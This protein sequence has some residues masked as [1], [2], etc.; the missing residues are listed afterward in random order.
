MVLETLRRLTSGPKPVIAVF[1]L[2]LTSLYLLSAAT[3]DS[4]D[5]GRMYSLLL[6]INIAALLLLAALI[7]RQLLHLVRQYRQRAP[8]ARLTGRL[9]VMFVILAV[10]P[11][12]VV[13][14]FSL[15][16]LHRGIES[17][18]DVKV[19]QALED[20]L[21]L[22]QTSLDGR[23]HELL[24]STR[25][26][27]IELEGV[28]KG[29][30][31]LRLSKLRQRVAASEITLLTHEG[32]VIA[33]AA[34]SSDIV[35][36]IP[37]SAVLFQLRQGIDYVGL[38]PTEGE[39]LQARI[40]VPVMNHLG[41]TDFRIL[42]A[43]YPIGE[44]VAGLA[45]SVQ[46]AYGQYKE[47]AYLR[48]PLK[49]SF[50]LTLSLVLLLSLL[51]AVW[52]AFFSARRL[53]APIR[54]LA[55]GTR[56]VAE[57]DYDKRLP[58]P[59]R[60]ELGF[61]V[62][63]FN[64][65]TRKIA[66]SR[67]E[68]SRSQGEV[69]AQR[70]YLEVVLG[71]LSSGVLT[72]NRYRRIRA[73]NDA[74]AHI[75]RLSPESLV[76]L[77]LEELQ[78][79]NPGFEPLVSTIMPRLDESSA[80]WRAEV[81]LFGS[82]GRQV[83]MCRGSALPNIGDI[84]GGHLIV[85]DDMTALIQAQR[86]AAWGEVARRLAHEIKN[87]L[88]PIQLSAERLR[89][90]YLK[91]MSEEDAEVL[92]RSTHTIMQQVD[93]MKDMVKAF[94][95]YARTPSMQIAPVDLNGIIEEVLDLYRSGGKELQLEAHLETAMPWLEADSGRLRQLLHNLIKNAIE[96]GGDRPVRVEV[97]THCMEREGCHFIDLQVR[98]NGP[99]IPDQILAQLFEPY[100]TT[101]L[102]GTGLGLA[103]VKKIVEEHGGML[104][105]KNASEGGAVITIRLPVH[106]EGAMGET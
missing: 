19:E 13:Y 26:I 77:P 60:D 36:A 29:L 37:N 105:A 54:D 3:H 38:E 63:S 80:E 32:R 71:R 102:R 69:E 53:V 59:S 30:A 31:A 42:H 65:M 83:L 27:S 21:A 94:S 16:Y 84:E 74:A 82:G 9:V 7:S 91:R 95:E 49:Y 64:E 66:L 79:E 47:L 5:F 106:P 44:R 48:Q 22:G 10:V 51:A 45:E 17:W 11:V 99:G 33:S 43:I 87:P 58:L 23:L 57:G 56:A 88:T 2:L 67:D 78:R 46:S 96:A 97:L 4:T 8:G 28:P 55:E 24:R 40:A 61:L 89:H 20:A 92:D 93:A 15:Q 52:A 100:V 34:G 81:V 73:I 12:S 103:I 1:A 75:L 68:A 25:T 14:Y 41:G 76:D 104:W 70:A 101:K 18:F 62:R 86:D 98:D 85:F 72:V 50:T 39:I 6:V 90:K 35:P